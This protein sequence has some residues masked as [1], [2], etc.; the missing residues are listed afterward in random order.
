MVN[1]VRNKHEQQKMH[2]FKSEFY[3]LIVVLSYYIWHFPLKNFLL[4]VHY[5]YYYYYYAYSCFSM[6]NIEDFLKFWL[7]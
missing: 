6:T 5:Y 1:H 2:Y 3:I 7:H 4:S